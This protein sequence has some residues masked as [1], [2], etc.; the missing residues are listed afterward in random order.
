MPFYDIKM[1]NINVR[2][3]LIIKIKLLRN[4]I[5]KANSTQKP[6]EK[7]SFSRQ[8]RSHFTAS[9]TE[10]LLIQ[11]L[12]EFLSRTSQGKLELQAS[13]SSLAQFSSPMSEVTS[14]SKGTSTFSKIVTELCLIVASWRSMAR[15]S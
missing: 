13:Q 6:E 3:G 8:N 5:N 1:L 4:L 10:L 14:V 7:N 2:N 9:I 12:Y 11:H 15:A